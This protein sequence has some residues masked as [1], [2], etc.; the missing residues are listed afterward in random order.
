MG[1]VFLAVEIDDAIVEQGTE[2][3][4]VLAQVGQRRPQVETEHGAHGGP[5][6]G[7]DAQ[8]EPAGG[9]LIQNLHLLGGHDGMARVGGND[10][11]SEKNVVG[12]HGGGGEQGQR[13]QPGSAGGEPGGLYAGRLSAAHEVQGCFGIGSAGVEADAF[14]GHG[15][16]P[17]N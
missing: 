17:R 13:V 2:D 5:V 8:T 4:Q 9:Q 12:L 14:G 6:A 1:G 11:R 7:A 16:L 3:N 10:G 15:E